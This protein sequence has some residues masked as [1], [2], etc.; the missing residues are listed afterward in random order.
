MPV[1]SPNL[2]NRGPVNSVGFGN[3]TQ[4]LPS[5]DSPDN[6]RPVS[7]QQC[8]QRWQVGWWQSAFFGVARAA[9]EQSGNMRDRHVKLSGYIFP[10]VSVRKQLSKLNDIRIRK[11]GIISPLTRR[12]AQ[13]SLFLGVL[14]VVLRAAQKQMTWIAASPVVASVANHYLWIRNLAKGQEPRN[15]VSVA[16]ISVVTTHSITVFG[17]ITNPRPALFRR[18][19]FNLLPELFRRHNMMGNVSGNT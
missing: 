11:F 9:V 1:F 15:S 14:N 18:G 7:Q 12:V 8:P 17:K 13:T 16:H 19:Y 6:Q 5:P 3:G 10:A 4:A 2:T